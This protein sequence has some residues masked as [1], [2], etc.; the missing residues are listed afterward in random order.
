MI[1]P[2]TDMLCSLLVSVYSV[3]NSVR[4][5][6]APFFSLIPLLLDAKACRYL[7]WQQ[8]AVTIGYC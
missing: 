7:C 5:F 3:I 8:R 4:V 2:I 6:V 1:I